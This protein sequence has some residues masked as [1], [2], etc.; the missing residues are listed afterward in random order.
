MHKIIED[1]TKEGK[2]IVLAVKTK[3]DATAR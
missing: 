3:W 1:L 2:N